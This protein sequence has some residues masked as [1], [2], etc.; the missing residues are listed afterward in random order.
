MMQVEEIWDS[1]YRYRT[2][3]FTGALP[4]SIH[5][6]DDVHQAG[7][8]YI[9]ERVRVSYFDDGSK[10]VWRAYVADVE[11]YHSITQAPVFLNYHEK[12]QAS[13]LSWLPAWLVPLVSEHTPG[14]RPPEEP[15][16][17]LRL[18]SPQ[19]PG[20]MPQFAPQP[21]A[22]PELIGES[23]SKL[24][25][26]DYEANLIQ[27]PSDPTNPNLFKLA[28]VRTLSGQPVRV[29]WGTFNGA[30]QETAPDPVAIT[31]VMPVVKE[32]SAS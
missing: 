7:E 11:G 23:L 4:Q 29:S 9:P 15:D 17:S 12:N 25:P 2:F 28:E 3:R 20:P 24:P 8:S 27:D 14:K 22:E 10:G 26:G 19:G 31:R 5:T 30:L 16:N 21:P 13:D 32:D 1:S 6:P 18:T